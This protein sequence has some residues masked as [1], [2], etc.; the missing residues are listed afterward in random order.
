MIAAS[1]LEAGHRVKVIPYDVW[2]GVE[3]VVERVL[4]SRSEVVGLAMQFQ[5]GA[6]GFLALA[7]RLRR[8]G[9]LG[10]IT[11]GGQYPTMTWRELLTHEPAIDS[12]VLHEGEHTVVEL[13]RALR[14]GSVLHD[15][16]G[17][18][19]RGHDGLP[20]RTAPRPL[21]TDLDHLP[22]AHRYRAPSR[23]LGIPFLPISGSR[24]CWGSC[25]FCAITTYYRD[26]HDHGVTGRKLR[27]RSPENIADEMAQL[28]RSE[29][30]PVLFC[31]HDDTLLLPRPADSLARLRALRVALD[32]RGVGPVGLV[33]K[34][35][36]DCVTEELAQAMRELGVIRMF[37]GIENGSQR[38]LDH[39]HRR[40]NTA[41]LERALLAYEKAGIFVCYNLLLFEPDC[42][43]DDLKENIAF[44]RCHAQVPVNFC[45][46]E[47]YNGT[48]LHQQVKDAGLLIGNYLG[49]DYRIKND[50]AELTFR[51]AAAAFRDRNYGLAGVANRT[52]G[53]GY[54][55][56]LLRR[57]YD[58]SSGQARELLGRADALV[59]AV[60]LD[61]AELLE[62]AMHL[63]ERADL[64]NHDRITRDAVM[65][66]LRVTAQDRV[67]HNAIDN[68]TEELHVFASSHPLVRPTISLPEKARAAMGRLAFATAMIASS[69][70]CG[71]ESESDE[72]A[73]GAPSGGASMVGDGG[74]PPY[75]GSTSTLL[76]DGGA[77]PAGGRATGGYIMSDMG[78]APTVGGKATGGASVNGDGGTSPTGGRATGGHIVTGDGGAPPSGGRAFGG[79]VLTDAGGPPVIGGAVNKGGSNTGGTAVRGGNTTIVGD[80]GALPT[81]GRATGGY[82]MSDMGGAPTLGG[83]ASTG[84]ATTGGLS[85]SAMLEPNS[86]SGFERSATNPVDPPPPPIP[87]GVL[88]RA[89]LGVVEHWHDSG[90]KRL[91]R[92]EDLPLSDP[93]DIKLESKLVGKEIAVTL[94][95][96]GPSLSVRWQCEGKV[97]GKGRH[98]RWVPASPDDALR[99]AARSPNGIV[100]AMLRAKELEH[101]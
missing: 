82:I 31:F 22:F 14:S 61:T 58:V 23:H 83:K 15:V 53:F 92:S 55:T 65:F 45:R 70:A 73:G 67:W 68:L 12:I 71:G 29:R 28:W 8:A 101:A 32:E 99:V 48:P 13:L 9:Y 63:A 95:G 93:P 18:A 86:S 17:L 20:L 96:G 43:L 35:R 50:R 59:R 3:A 64:S 60:S 38:G 7:E 47:P 2:D 1:L 37:V 52:M 4:L 66:G 34:C 94:C 87:P 51:I 42:T 76:G 98:V 10:H 85:S 78:G 56:Q 79:Y 74:A 39:L 49:W 72:G 21:C 75:G 36:P 81:G 26:A 77:P 33:G 24:G 6:P 89:R 54:I 69:Q 27:W 16:P 40:T 44:I 41:D 19:L 62:A 46:A 11:C 30:T 91:T 97:M 80:G 90:P 25:S 88:A 84:G 57:F 5:H 100:F